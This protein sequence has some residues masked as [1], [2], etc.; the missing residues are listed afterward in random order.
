MHSNSSV[1]LVVVLANAYRK[2]DWPRVISS[3]VVSSHRLKMSSIIDFLS[4][5]SLSH[6]WDLE[7]D[8]SLRSE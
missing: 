8:P 4:T 2:T 6:S 5:M 1:S 7:N 3:L